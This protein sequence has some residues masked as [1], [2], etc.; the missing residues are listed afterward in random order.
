MKYAAVA[1]PFLA[2]ALLMACPPPPQSGPPPSGPPTGQVP[3]DGTGYETPPPPPDGT[4][5]DPTPTLAADGEPC[6]QHA[7]CEGGVCEG[8]GCGAGQG[9]CASKDRMCTRDYVTYCGCDGN[10]FGG[11]GSCPG[12]RY[13]HKGPCTTRL[14]DGDACTTAD[15]C[16]SGVCEG[17]GCG[18]A[19]GVCAPRNRACTKDLRAYCGCDGQTFRTSGSCP[20]QRFSH[21]GECK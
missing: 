14:A 13:A 8:E 11:S 12:D 15:Q 2:L 3:G 18:D 4:G 17:E 10:E 6:T 5:T 7:D 16:A 9:M 20:G 21:R 1:F 19:N